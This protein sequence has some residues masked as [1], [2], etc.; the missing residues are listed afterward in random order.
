MPDF[1]DI[2]K[3]VGGAV[4]A[5]KDKAEEARPAVESAAAAVK[6]VA[7]NVA[8]AAGNVAADLKPQ[9]AEVA[10]SACPYAQVTMVAEAPVRT[11]TPVSRTSQALLSMFT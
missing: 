10:S 2:K 6:E 8:E 1:E 7:G 5:A 9:M 11:S 4:D 3:A